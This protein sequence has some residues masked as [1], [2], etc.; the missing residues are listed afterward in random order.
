MV[1]D[2]PLVERMIE[3]PD[4]IIIAS[5]DRDWHYTPEDPFAGLDMTPEEIERAKAWIKTGVWPDAK[6]SESR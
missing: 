5:D 6:P 2:K 1:Q 3:N 4:E